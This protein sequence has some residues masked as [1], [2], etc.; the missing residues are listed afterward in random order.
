MLQCVYTWLIIQLCGLL[1][2]LVPS[3]TQFRLPTKRRS[4]AEAG[5]VVIGA[6]QVVHALVDVLGLDVVRVEELQRR[7]DPYGVGGAFE[8]IA[9]REDGH[10]DGQAEI[11]LGE[12]GGGRE[13]VPGGNVDV[14]GFEA[15]IPAAT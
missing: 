14:K 3:E 12:V 8:R 6:E 11:D 5:G 4:Q 1:A 13:R 7:V 10:R 2:R 15:I 9:Q